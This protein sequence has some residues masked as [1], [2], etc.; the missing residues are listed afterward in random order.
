MKRN[1]FFQL[2]QKEDGLYNIMLYIEVLKKDFG[3]II[4]QSEIEA[5]YKIPGNVGRPQL[6]LLLIKLCYLFVF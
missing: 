5:L 2:V 1:A 3:I 6:A 4:P